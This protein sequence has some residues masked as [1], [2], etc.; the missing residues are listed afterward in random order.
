[1]V[2]PV[3]TIAVGAG[4][5]F[6]REFG[7]NDIVTGIWFGALIVSSIAWMIDWLNRKNIH[8]LF[9][10]ILVIV[11]F[12]ALFVL[13]LYFW[14]VG[15]VAIMGEATNVIF[16]MDKILFGVILGSFIFI[17]AVLADGYLRK[18]NEGKHLIIYQKVIIPIVFLIIAS[19]MAEL[20]IK[21]GIFA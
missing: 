18:V 17:A 2:C 19:I 5:G 21:I 9:R 10:K 3:C 20:L 1:M 13:P 6:L 14:K 12:Y 16:G 8:F 15:G 4:V 7:V 11:S